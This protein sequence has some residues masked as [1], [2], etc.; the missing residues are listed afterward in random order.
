MP[1]QRSEEE[2]GTTNRGMYHINSSFK[3][4]AH[5]KLQRCSPHADDVN[6]LKKREISRVMD[7]INAYMPGSGYAVKM[8]F[9]SVKKFRNDKTNR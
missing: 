5:K 3:I 9:E 2:N 4:N 8:H 7:R 1:D 6:A